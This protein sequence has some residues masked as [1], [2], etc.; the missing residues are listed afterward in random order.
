MFG[1]RHYEEPTPSVKMVP[2]QIIEP[3]ARKNVNVLHEIWCPH[4]MS[5]GP[6]TMTV[7]SYSRGEVTDDGFSIA[8][9]DVIECSISTHTTAECLSCGYE[10]S[11][12]DFN[13]AGPLTQFVWS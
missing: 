7:L 5:E 10:G 12:D 1:K 11:Y 3:E 4:C 2:A 6:F 13:F 8:E 9:M